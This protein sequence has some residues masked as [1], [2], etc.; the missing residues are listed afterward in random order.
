MGALPPPEGEEVGGYTVNQ[1]YVE[2]DDEYDRPRRRSR[3]SRDYDDEWDDRTRQPRQPSLGLALCASG[4]WIGSV[5]LLGC[6]FLWQTYMAIQAWKAPATYLPSTLMTFCISAFV[7][8]MLVIFS[9]IVAFGT[10]SRRFRTI[11]LA[12]LLSIVL[13]IVFVVVN[14]IMGSIIGAEAEAD[15]LVPF[16]R[17]KSTEM[18]LTA[19]A[20]GVGV[21]VPLG[22]AGILALCGAA[23]YRRWKNEQTR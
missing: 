22:I 20:R 15:P 18:T 8:L 14:T 4:F 23:N 12:G 13:A 9:S 6:V 5:I 19:F 1:R 3:R 16:R 11:L 7:S 21:T 2:D 17:G 10:I